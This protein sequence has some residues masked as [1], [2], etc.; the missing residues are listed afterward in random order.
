ME[1]AMTSPS[2]YSEELRQNWRQTAVRQGLLCLVCSQ[3]PSL[4]H[5][6]EFYDTGLCEACALE[7]LARTPASPMA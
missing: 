6:A 2:T 5:R 4:E 3:A 7:L 1:A